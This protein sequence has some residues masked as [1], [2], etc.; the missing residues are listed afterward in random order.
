MLPDERAALTAW[1][2]AFTELLNARPTF[3]SLASDELTA[4]TFPPV[5]RPEELL[6]SNGHF[7]HH[8]AMVEHVRGLGF[9]WDAGGRIRT[10]PTPGTFNR[11]VDALG[12]SNVGFRPQLFVEG[13]SAMP[14]GRWLTLVLDG[15]LPLQVSTPEWSAACLTGQTALS[16][17][18]RLRLQVTSLAHDLT[19]HVLN[20]HLIPRASV[21]EMRA[22]IEAT[23]PDRV[24]SWREPGAGAPLTLSYFIDNDLNRYCYAVWC[25]TKK[26]ADFAAIFQAPG[27]IDQLWTALSIRLEETATGKGDVPDGN[28]DR[29]G[30]LRPTTFEL[31]R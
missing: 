29:M 30:P 31:K 15:V 20:Y 23:V 10:A 7:R 1:A 18:S 22:R 5:I 14:L 24:A 12:F 28:T 11:L 21:A 4:I 19:V 27:N 3:A 9:D 6:G 13:R 8:P 2:D 17:V 25:L 16:A 26:P